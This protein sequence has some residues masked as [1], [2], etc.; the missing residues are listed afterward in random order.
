MDYRGRITVYDVLGYLAG[1][2]NE[3]D[4]LTDFPASRASLLDAQHR[5]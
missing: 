5:A 4:I 1:G 3:D 2:M